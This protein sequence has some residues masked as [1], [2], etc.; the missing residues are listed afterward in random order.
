MDSPSLQEHFLLHLD[1][2]LIQ[3]RKVKAMLLHLSLPV[4]GMVWGDL[5]YEM[6]CREE[7]EKTMIWNRVVLSHGKVDKN[8]SQKV[9]I[10]LLLFPEC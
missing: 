10:F 8:N 1:S 2:V 3:H 7:K 9:I 4:L 6:G 5:D